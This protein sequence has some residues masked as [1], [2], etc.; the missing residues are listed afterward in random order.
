MRAT[1]LIITAGVLVSVCLL[2]LGCGS[3]G[4]SESAAAMAITL[5]DLDGNSI[6]V[7]SY[8]GQ[9]IMLNF[10]ATWCPPCRQEIPDFIELQKELGPKGLAI[11]GVSLDQAEVSEISGISR[12]LKINY[13]VL[14][15]GGQADRIVKGLGDF[16][17]IPT[18]FLIDR[19]GKI[20]S[21]I[22]GARPKKFW[23]KEI[24]DLL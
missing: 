7:S 24:G 9:V 4:K 1:R 18:T 21:T 6:N 2:L 11:I 3:S 17:S 15:A 12:D 16:S 22:T 23:Q 10:W 13:P 19:N 8:Q 5:P 14:Y 20:V